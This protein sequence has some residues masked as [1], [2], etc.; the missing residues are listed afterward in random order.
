MYCIDIFID[1]LP[2]RVRKRGEK[3]NFRHVDGPIGFDDL[4]SGKIAACQY[5][6]HNY[7]IPG[8]RAALNCF[9]NYFFEPTR[10][11]IPLPASRLKQNLS[12]CATMR[13]MRDERREWWRVRDAQR[14]LRILEEFADRLQNKERIQTIASVF[15]LPDDQHSC[16]IPRDIVEYNSKDLTSA[17]IVTLFNCL[18][19]FH[20]PLNGQDSQCVLIRLAEADATKLVAAVRRY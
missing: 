19:F 13:A 7:I 17:E 16:S 9:C 15:G 3:R 4:E 2:P 11:W 14:Q 1:T 12:K 6:L 10:L 5:V 18:R 8:W 20:F